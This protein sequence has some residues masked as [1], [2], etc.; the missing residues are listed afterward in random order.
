MPPYIKLISFFDMNCA[1]PPSS[2]FPGNMMAV[3]V[4]KDSRGS[5]IAAFQARLIILI[6][7]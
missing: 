5:H 2:I 6:Q 4:E 1:P 3:A 7:G